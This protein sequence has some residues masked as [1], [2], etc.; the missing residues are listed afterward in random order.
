MF[1]F[2]LNKQVTNISMLDGKSDILSWRYPWWQ[3]RELILGGMKGVGAPASIASP[4]R[5]AGGESKMVAQEQEHPSNCTEIQ[6]YIL[7][8]NTLLLLTG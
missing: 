5:T 7:F 4:D 1:A 3:V 8:H 2:R 6:L